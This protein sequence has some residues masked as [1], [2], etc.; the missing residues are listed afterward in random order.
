MCKVK[1]KVLALLL[2]V[3]IVAGTTSCAKI[4]ESAKTVCGEYIT[5][6]ASGDGAKAQALSDLSDED[7]KSYFGNSYK[8]E[9]VSCILSASTY[10]IDDENSLARPKAGFGKMVCVFSIPD[11]VS[12][13]AS[14]P[15]DYEDFKAK[16]LKAKTNEVT[17]EI[18]LKYADGNWKVSSARANLDAILGPLY[19]PDY[20]FF[21][22][23]D[24]LFDSVELDYVSN[25][26]TSSISDVVTDASELIL[27]V[28]LSRFGAELFDELDLNYE[29][30]N[31][32]GIIASGTPGIRGKN[33]MLIKMPASE[34]TV[35]SKF[36]PQDTYT[37][38]LYRGEVLVW[39]DTFDVVLTEYTIPS[40]SIV[41]DIF[42]QHTDSSGSY[43]NAKQIE[44]KIV[45][46]ESYLDS[47]RDSDVSFSIYNESG[48]LIE[49]SHF[50]VEANG[51]VCIYK[52]EELL[53]TGTYVIEVY[54]NDILAG[55]ASVLVINNMDPERYKEEPVA[56]NVKDESDGKIAIYSGSSGAVDMISKYSTVK[57]DKKVLTLNTFRN[58]LDAM[59][60]SGDNAPD[61]FICD[62]S[63]ASHYAQSDFTV[64]LNS[65][66]IDYDEFKFMYEYT[67]AMGMNSDGVIKGVTWEIQ[68]GAV[69][70]NRSVAEKT[71]GVSEPKD[72]QPYF[73]TWDSFMSTA[74][75][76][77]E[78]TNGST[79]IVCDVADI[80][81]PYILGRQE[82]WA[83]NGEVQVSDYMTDF[84]DI[85]NVLSSEELTFGSARWSTEW[86][87]RMSNKSVLSYFGTLEFGD[88]FLTNTGSN[89]GVVRAP[90]DYYDGGYYIFVTKYCD[91]N[92]SA[93]QIIRDISISSV[94]LE[95]MAND[96]STVNNL[97]IMLS[98]AGDDSYSRKWLAGQN[99]YT[100]FTG[101]AWNLNGRSI[102]VYD[103][104][105]N[106]LFVDTVKLY[107]NGDITSVDNA[108]N[109]FIKE[110]EALIK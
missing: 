89:W 30:S 40:R 90:E 67:F 6:V 41:N 46:N 108:K 64:P 10:I 96:G 101:A 16:L 60:A 4:D 104:E 62:I 109:A 83:V 20:E 73:S 51:Y 58:D 75:Y 54:N 80:E 8:E 26:S 33:M 37:L 7:V 95:K 74:K 31:S 9:V 29:L 99:P 84:F 43:F 100:V 14:N 107:T 77:N 32:S 106:S 19:E 35:P 49:D 70:Y 94:N 68:P 65:I 93:A 71:L 36:V 27:D 53:A 105:I 24:C 48:F 2:A 34:F 5:A 3:T 79:R 92:A 69:F 12:V 50:D 59:L 47:G 87:G 97:N 102:S 45:F 76:L 1:E 82:A 91:K 15:S 110:A 23:S 38:K 63:Y 72:V 52:S 17:V 13:D 44:A 55:S 39:E 85:C 88:L 18:D 28:Q 56:T 78:N 11:Y 61:M 42:W 103:D 25:T 81:E 66:G 86:S 21:L 98:C 57:Y 22:D